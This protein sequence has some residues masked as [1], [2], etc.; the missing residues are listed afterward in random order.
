MV[1]DVHSTGAKFLS[2]DTEVLKTFWKTFSPSLQT[3]DEI[4]LSGPIWIA[5]KVFNWESQMKLH[6]FRFKISEC[7]TTIWNFSSS[8]EPSLSTKW[9]E[10]KFSSWNFKCL[11]TQKH[12][13]LWRFRSRKLE[14]KAKKPEPGTKYGP[15][16]KRKST[17]PEEIFRC[18]Q[19]PNTSSRIGLISSSLNMVGAGRREASLMIGSTGY[20]P[21]FWRVL[22]ARYWVEV[23]VGRQVGHMK[24]TFR[25][26]LVN[27]VE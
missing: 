1:Y 22:L 14:L 5:Q 10:L 23:R 26:S 8:F 4:R 6:S 12:R 17:L 15:N 9:K 27:F 20:Y 18:L 2:K 16:W 11:A 19:T 21:D 3:T 13:A 7:L 24:V 25:V